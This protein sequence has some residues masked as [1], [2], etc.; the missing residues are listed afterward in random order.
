MSCTVSF[1]GKSESPPPPPP[2]PLKKKKKKGG[3]PPHSSSSFFPPPAP[4]PHIKQR[5]QERFPSYVFI[6]LSSTSRDPLLRSASILPPPLVRTCGAAGFFVS[7]PSLPPPWPQRPRR[8]RRRRP[9]R[10]NRS[11]RRCLP[12][13]GSRTSSSRRSLARGSSGTSTT[14][15]GPRRPRRIPAPEPIRPPPRTAT[16]AGTISSQPSSTA[17]SVLP[18]LIS[19]VT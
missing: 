1:N 3:P 17:V 16:P 19:S 18:F 4:L 11:T 2:P 7:P 14:C 12:C 9:R 13:C 10:R 6:A 15:S 8:R 5:K